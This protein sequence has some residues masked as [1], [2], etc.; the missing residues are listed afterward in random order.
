MDRTRFLYNQSAS[1]L[2]V[3][4]GIFKSRTI[5]LSSSDVFPINVFVCIICRETGSEKKREDSINLRALY[6]YKPTLNKSVID[7]LLFLHFLEV[8]CRIE[9][10]LRLYRS[11]AFALGFLP[12]VR[13][14]PGFRFY[15]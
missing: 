3:N 13:Y 12:F 7:C 6:L 2:A 1:C 11:F 8:K 9:L 14:M 5:D 10:H 15:P 4:A